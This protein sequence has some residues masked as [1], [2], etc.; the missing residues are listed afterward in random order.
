[1]TT[2]P[3]T[4]LALPPHYCYFIDKNV[5]L[6]VSSAPFPREFLYQ[7]YAT[8]TLKAVANTERAVV[9]GQALV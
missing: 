7:V 4:P 8:H 3:P 2:P 1:M 5:L 6:L 9:L